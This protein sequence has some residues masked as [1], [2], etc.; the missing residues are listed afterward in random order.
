MDFKTKT[1]LCIARLYNSSACVFW[2]AQTPTERTQWTNVWSYWCRNKLEVVFSCRVPCLW[3]W[4]GIAR[5]PFPPRA[6]SCCSA[7]AEFQLWARQEGAPSWRHHLGA[8]AAA[9]GS[10]SVGTPELSRTMGNPPGLGIVSRWMCWLLL[11]PVLQQI[12]DEGSPGLQPRGRTT[13]GAALT[14]QRRLRG[15]PR[16]E[17]CS[18]NSKSKVPRV[19]HSRLVLMIKGKLHPLCSAWVEL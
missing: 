8:A 15:F 2:L 1:A 9:P 14:P 6:G 18:L 11:S 13:L 4:S 7:R 3:A 19:L 10:G 16:T 17:H 12:W 5:T